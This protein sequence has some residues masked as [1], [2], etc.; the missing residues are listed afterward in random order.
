MIHN[1]PSGGHPDSRV[2][3]CCV[4]YRSSSFG[5]SSTAPILRTGETSTAHLPVDCPEP[6]FL[7]GYD[8]L[9]KSNMSDTK[10]SAA[11]ERRS[12]SQSEHFLK[13]H[14]SQY[15]QTQSRSAK[16][17]RNAASKS[18]TLPHADV[19]PQ[20]VELNQTLIVPQSS[21]NG[22]DPD[23]HKDRNPPQDTGFLK[24]STNITQIRSISCQDDS[25]PQS[26]SGST[27]G[28]HHNIN[29]QQTINSQSSAP[30]RHHTLEQTYSS[31][32]PPQESLSSSQSETVPQINPLL[33]TINEA[34]T[35]PGDVAPVESCMTCPQ[36]STSI[37]THSAQS[38]PVSRSGLD[39]NMP[40]SSSLTTTATVT[41]KIVCQSSTSGSYSSDRRSQQERPFSQGSEGL[42]ADPHAPN[43][44]NNV[45]ISSSTT[46]GSNRL[47]SKPSHQTVYSLHEPLA[48]T[49]TQQCVHDPGMNPSS[50]TQLAAP[51]PKAHTQALAQQA[52]LHVTSPSSS[53]HLLTPDQDPD[54]CQPMAIR[55]EI[56]R[57]PQIQGPPLPVP[58]P[59]P[60]AQTESL[61]QGKA[62][63][64]G[65]PCV[66][67]P[68]S[69]AT[70]MEGS[71]VTLEVEVMGHPEPM[72]T[73]WV[74][75][76]QLHNN[77]QDL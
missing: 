74:A 59:L 65:P 5:Q 36:L 14:S 72:L 44:V 43:S 6:S 26:V 34:R 51:Q 12:P 29:I 21:F 61:P 58:P 40:Q 54:I 30:D 48:S 42:P 27:S 24:F 17:T 67:R 55:E 23:L 66:T 33:H 18:D 49:S 20:A 68:L 57:T 77:T 73:W 35:L 13:E 47:S 64:S 7:S 70:V 31:V 69:R 60:R 9:H 50:N 37:H 2:H 32:V 62:S 46:T 19:I 52:N 1:N 25:F 15:E 38:H 56:R 28:L 16:V 10:H 71:P 76:N 75:Y 8:Q 4:F 39:Q 3:S 41:Q 63:K 11:P 45:S 53:P 22:K